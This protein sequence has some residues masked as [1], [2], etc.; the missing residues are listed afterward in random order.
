[1]VS[2]LTTKFGLY[3]LENAQD[4]AQETLEVAYQNWSYKGIPENPEAWIFVVA[5]NKAINIVKKD[6]KKSFMNID[7]LIKEADAPDSNIN[8][9]KEVDDSMLRM[10]FACCSTRLSTKNQI[11]LILSTLGGFS[12]RE[13]A[14]ALF[15]EEESI[16]KS[17]YR[18]KKKIRETQLVLNIPEGTNL[19]PKLHIVANALYILFN[20]G[21]NS[22]SNKELIRKDICL[23]AMRL[24]KLLIAHFPDEAMIHAL[25]ALMCFHVARF[26]SRIDHQGAIVLFK[27]QDRTLWN[28]ELIQAGIVHLSSASKGQSLSSYHIEAGI[29]LEHCT[30]GSYENTNWRLIHQLY[31]QLYAFKPSPII[32]LNLA[33]VNSRILGVNHAIDEL[34]ELKAEDQKL[35]K[36]YLLYATLGEFYKIK[37][38]KE[39]A[40]VNFEMAKKLTSSLQEQQLLDTKMGA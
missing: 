8:L 34:E 17:L 36:Y 11:I 35:K 29:A 14:Q 27:D 22:S 26:D 19:K 1:M 30:A 13:I 16:K 9:D 3:F 40:Q 38:L 4:V 24:C 23:E 25:F 12:R 7:Q 20:E 10:I 32:K 18:S 2:Y 33:I 31:G 21:Y 37:N 6:K 15:E 39:K 28:K 5:K